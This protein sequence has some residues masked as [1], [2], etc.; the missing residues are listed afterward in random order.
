MI[1]LTELRAKLKKNTIKGY[2]HY[3]KS[4]LIDVLVKI[5]L[6]PQ[7]ITVTTIASLPERE[8]TKI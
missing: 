7:T 2:L 5:G 4:E 3:N 6:L 8:N 1:N